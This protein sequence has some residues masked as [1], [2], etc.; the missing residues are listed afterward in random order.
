MYEYLVLW[1]FDTSE[2]NFVKFGGK[3]EEE[4]IKET[5]FFKFAT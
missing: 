4:P 2:Q 3:V 5:R 1:S